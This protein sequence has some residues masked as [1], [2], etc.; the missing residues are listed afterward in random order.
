MTLSEAVITDIVDTVKAFPPFRLVAALFFLC[1]AIQQKDHPRLRQALV[2]WFKNGVC[3]KLPEAFETDAYEFYTDFREW[4][5]DKARGVTGPNVPLFELLSMGGIVQSIQGHF[6]YDYPRLAEE[7]LLADIRMQLKRNDA[8]AYGLS[9]YA[10]SKTDVTL[11]PEL[12]WEPYA[13]VERFFHDT[14]FYDFFR[15]QVPFR[16]KRD[17]WP[18]HAVI[19]APSEWGK[20]ELT[21]LFLRE[22]LEDPE[23]RAVI[24]CD[25]HGDLYKKALPRVP[26]DRLIAIDLTRNPPDLNILDHGVL[27]E[28]DALHTFRFLIS[29]LAGGLSPKQ[30]ACIRPLFSLLKLIPDATLLTLHEI[31][32]EQVTKASKSQY[33]PYIEQLNPIHKAFFDNLWFSGKSS[34][35]RE[36]LLWKVGAVIDDPT[37]TRMFSAKRNSMNIPRWIEERKVVLIKS[38]DQLDK[39]GTRLFFLYIIGQ[40][41]AAAKRRD[42]LHPSKRHLAQMFFDEASVVLQSPIISDLLVEI[43][44]YNCAFIAATQ[45]WHHVAQEVRPAVLGST[46]IRILGQLGHDEASALY[47]DMKVALETITGLHAVP[48]QYAQ[49]CFFV[50]SVTQK[51]L[52][53]K[54]PYGALEAMPIINQNVE[55]LSFDDDDELEKHFEELEREEGAP[56][57]NKRRAVR[58]YPVVIT[59]ED[60]Q[61]D[62]DACYD[63]AMREL[64]AEAKASEA[65]IK[66]GRDWSEPT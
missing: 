11:P 40:Y 62:F 24:L 43:R 7:G 57:S 21:G 59:E 65:T 38:S 26:A 20:S 2:A 63:K 66:P 61:E 4:D 27:P 35:T 5:R 32:A 50:R 3:K 41:Y 64:E 1:E 54:V 44:K 29:S 9:V 13:F 30:E 28:R 46:G 42:A 51:G 33:A 22:A 15:T 8:E 39:E 36:A 18:T 53:V 16:I 49:W 25:P 37:F 48:W 55:T 60:I 6:L 34:D 31:I 52:V 19:I 58:A 12:D 17:R 47:R 14:P 56:P 23:P 10:R 45:L